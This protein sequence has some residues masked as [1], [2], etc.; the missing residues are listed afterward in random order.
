MAFCCQ[1]IVTIRVFTVKTFATMGSFPLYSSIRK[2]N[3]LLNV[4]FSMSRFTV[5]CDV[6]SNDTSA[7]RIRQIKKSDIPVVA[8]ICHEVRYVREFS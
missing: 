7:Y 5:R 3:S 4:E 2:G 6:N 1:I 8:E